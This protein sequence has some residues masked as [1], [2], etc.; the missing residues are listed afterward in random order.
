MTKEIF[1]AFVKH[2]SGGPDVPNDYQATRAAVLQMFP[3]LASTGNWGHA[4]E[5]AGLGVLARPSINHL[6]GKE[7]S[8]KSKALHEVG[9]LGILAAPSAYEMGKSFLNRAKPAAANVAG[10]LIAHH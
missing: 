9:G 5:I 4:A 7:M 6:R 1:R 3:K 2:A 10:H 8:E